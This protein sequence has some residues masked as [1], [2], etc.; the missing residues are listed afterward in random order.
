MP[1][2]A[3]RTP[4]TLRQV[5]AAQLRVHGIELTSLL[6][7]N[8]ARSFNDLRTEIATRTGVQLSARTLRRWR[9]E[10]S[11]PAPAEVAS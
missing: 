8:P 3:H 2:M 9:D 7:Q 11:P 5:V 1:C 10:L 4:S 6:S